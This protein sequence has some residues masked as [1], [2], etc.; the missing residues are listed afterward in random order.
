MNNFDCI[1]NELHNKID[2]IKTSDELYHF[3]TEQ[4]L[5]DQ[6][7]WCCRKC[8]RIYGICPDTLQDD[9]LC[10]ERFYQWC[11]QETKCK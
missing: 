7:R 11:I 6:M 10:R 2:E 4:T 3:L 8:E 1:I 5:F 9:Q